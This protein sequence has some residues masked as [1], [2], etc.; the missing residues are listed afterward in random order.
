MPAKSKSRKSATKTF[1]K[2]FAPFIFE[3]GLFA[4]GEG[5]IDIRY[6]SS[7]DRAHEVCDAIIDAIATSLGLATTTLWTGEIE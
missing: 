5:G 3:M 2:D 4:D 6:E 7:D 1:P